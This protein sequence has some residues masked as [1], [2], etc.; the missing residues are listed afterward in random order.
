MADDG[1][2]YS[3][4]LAE[5]EVV[6]AQV[7]ALQRQVSSGR[8][9]FRQQAHGGPMFKVPNVSQLLWEKQRDLEDLERRIEQ[10]NDAFS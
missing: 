2:E 4:L 7:A 1:G 9:A 10:L 8:P 6:S 5:H 3:R